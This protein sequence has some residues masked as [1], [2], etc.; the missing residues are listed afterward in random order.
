MEKELAQGEI[1]K[2][3]EYELEYKEGK[4][5]FTLD[6]DTKGVDAGLY[7]DLDPDYFIDK[8]AKAI[9]GDLDDMVLAM[10]KSAL[11]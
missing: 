11:K 8:L 1:G 2:T 3:G 7:I 9:P 10:L 4:L 5:R 6:I